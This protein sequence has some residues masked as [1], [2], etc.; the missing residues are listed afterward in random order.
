MGDAYQQINIEM[1]SHI[2][3]RSADGFY[4]AECRCD[5]NDRRGNSS[6]HRKSIVCHVLPAVHLTFTLLNEAGRTLRAESWK[7]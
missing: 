4:G 1:N 6:V 3:A 2:L 5:A 7:V